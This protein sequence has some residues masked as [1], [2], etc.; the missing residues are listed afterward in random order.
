MKPVTEMMDAELAAAKADLDSR[1]RVLSSEL[2]EVKETLSKVEKEQKARF[3]EAYWQARP[4]LKPMKEGKVGESLEISAIRFDKHGEL[5]IEIADEDGDII[6]TCGYTEAREY[7]E[8]HFREIA[9][10][11]V[12][13]DTYRIEFESETDANGNVEWVARVPELPGCEARWKTLRGLE[14]VIK[15]A[16]IDYI[17][18]TLEAEGTHNP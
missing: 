15:A 11:Q 12:S 7:I 5:E 16:M 13:R 10:L 8:D 9:G 1:F 17:A 6:R 14:M 2:D 4:Q 18:E 3:M